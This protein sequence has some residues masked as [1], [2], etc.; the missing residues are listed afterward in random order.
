MSDMKEK[1]LGGPW[2]DKDG[3]YHPTTQIVP[4]IKK[5]DMRKDIND[6]GRISRRTKKMKYGNYLND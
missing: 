5:D 4:N 6:Y 1:R 3:N 2:W